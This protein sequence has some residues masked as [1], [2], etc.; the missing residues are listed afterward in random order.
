M[1]PVMFCMHVSVSLVPGG[2]DIILFLYFPPLFLRFLLLP[3]SCCFL[4]LD[5]V[6][7]FKQGACTP[8][9]LRILR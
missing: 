6:V 2:L 7:E 4:F 1:W 5:A 3:F 8:L 9:L